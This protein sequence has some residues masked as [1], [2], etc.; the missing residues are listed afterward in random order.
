MPRVNV[1]MKGPWMP[2]CR[3]P[4]G[5]RPKFGMWLVHTYLPRSVANLMNELAESEI[6]G[7]GD[8]LGFAMERPAD[9]EPGSVVAIPSQTPAF[10]TENAPDIWVTLEL[11]ET[12]F[13]RYIMG[14]ILNRMPAILAGAVDEFE[15]FQANIGERPQID[16]DLKLL[17]GGGFTMNT[18][19]EV[20]STWPKGTD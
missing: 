16:F 11:A 13:R 8:S 6:E 19:L 5:L 17:P 2:P 9:T 12:G 1:E 18:D 15:E 10:A 7:Y 14:S 3:N 4:N 20:V